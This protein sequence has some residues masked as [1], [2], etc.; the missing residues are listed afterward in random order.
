M[1]FYLDQKIT[2]VDKVDSKRRQCKIVGVD[3]DKKILR[4]HYI[5]WKSSHDENIPFDSP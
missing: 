2:V 4:I 3:K 5:N 1:E